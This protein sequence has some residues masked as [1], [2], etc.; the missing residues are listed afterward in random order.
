[1]SQTQEWA[2][3]PSNAPRSTWARTWHH[4]SRLHRYQTVHVRYFFGR[5]A[6]PRG[7]SGKRLQPASQVDI[8]G[9]VDN[10]V[11][12]REPFVG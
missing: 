2:E 1:M 12:R 10:D 4:R 11:K 3:D 7:Q 9:V 5:K 8:F 6:K